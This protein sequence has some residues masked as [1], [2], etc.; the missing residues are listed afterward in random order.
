M[1]S[2]LKMMLGDAIPSK[3][4]FREFPFLVGWNAHGFPNVLSCSGEILTAVGEKTKNRIL[5]QKTFKVSRCSGKFPDGLEKI[6]MAWI[7]S[8]WLEKFPD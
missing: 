3:N 2:P 1:L 7:V 4:A 6:Q 5:A 8:S